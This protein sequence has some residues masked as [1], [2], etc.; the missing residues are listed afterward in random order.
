[1]NIWVCISKTPDTTTKIQ[2]TSDGGDWV[3]E[4]VQF[5]INPYD[6]HALA[7]ALALKEKAGGTVSVIMVDDDAATADPVLRKA[8]AIGADKAVRINARPADSGYVAA[9]LAHYLK[10][11]AVDVVLAGRESIDSNGSGVGDM[12]GG[13]CHWASVSF[14]KHFEVADGGV[15]G[16]RFIEGGEEDFEAVLPVVLSVSKEVAE[17]RIPNM[18]GIMMAR[19]KPLEVV[20]P[21]DAPIYTEVVRY[22]PPKSRDKCKI[23]GPD[24]V[25]KLVEALQR[26]AK[27]I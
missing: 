26:E 11:Q 27:V 13:R 6:D 25:D 24:E 16:T 19:R 12:I 23:F 22:E 17:P 9:Q 20:D 14:V 1:M 4:G 2:F 3:R 21:I 5:I 10:D 8:L 7:A 15:R 18:R